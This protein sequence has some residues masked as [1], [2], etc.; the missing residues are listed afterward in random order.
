MAALRLFMLLGGRSGQ[1]CTMPRGVRGTVIS[2][3]NRSV[4]VPSCPARPRPAALPC[5]APTR[6]ARG[7]SGF[8][9]RQIRHRTNRWSTAVFV[10]LSIYIGF[11]LFVLLNG[12]WGQVRS[13][14][15]RVRRTVAFWANRS[16]GVPSCLA[17]PHSAAPLCGAPTRPARGMSGF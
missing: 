15:R 14:P 8:W 5:A 12:R 4:G 16:V 1:V 13:M 10:P 9:T 3:A 6:P 2:W 7:M 11:R 17:P